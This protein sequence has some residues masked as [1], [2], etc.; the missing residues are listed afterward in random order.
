MHAE[1]RY[2]D[3]AIY[4]RIGTVNEVL[5][6]WGWTLATFFLGVSGWQAIQRFTQPVAEMEVK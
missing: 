1:Y 3:N 2:S 6:P 5:T 4:R